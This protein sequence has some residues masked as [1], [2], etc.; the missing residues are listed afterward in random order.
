[1]PTDFK[2]LGT[3]SFENVKIKGLYEWQIKPVELI[4]NVTFSI[5]PTTLT[6]KPNDFHLNLK[7]QL[8]LF[9]V[10]RAIKSLNVKGWKYD[11]SRYTYSHDYTQVKLERVSSL[12]I[13][14]YFIRTDESEDI[15]T[16]YQSI[17]KQISELEIFKSSE[18]FIIRPNR[19]NAKNQ[20]R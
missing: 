10:D 18:H 20:C 7:Q 13:D 3:V 14:L 9:S 16:F 8:S 2:N 6:E 15:E 4:A 11:G 1:M 5:V 12:G 19:K 17:S